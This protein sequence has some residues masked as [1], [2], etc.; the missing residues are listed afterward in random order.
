MSE[1]DIT[2]HAERRMQQRSISNFDIDLILRYGE[3]IDGDGILMSNRAADDAIRSLKSRIATV[4]RLRNKKLVMDGDT[5]ITC[6]QC[7][8]HEGRRMKKR[9]RAH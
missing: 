8:I 2:R 1:V 4:E 7:K 9:G 5:L 3:D 6:Y